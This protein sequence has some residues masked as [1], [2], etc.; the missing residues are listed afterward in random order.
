VVDLKIP[1]LQGDGDEQEKEGRE[2]GRK[3][4]K[5]VRGRKFRH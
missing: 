3:R 1:W 2:E 5:G 4:K